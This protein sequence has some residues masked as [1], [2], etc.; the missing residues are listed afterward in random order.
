[1]ENGTMIRMEFDRSMKKIN[2]KVS[3]IG[4]K[5]VKVKKSSIGSKREDSVLII[6]D[7]TFIHYIH[8]GK[9]KTHLIACS[10]VDLGVE[11][12]LP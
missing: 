2:H 12:K 10:N 3:V 4:S 1:M 11:M 5:P 7:K 6:S 8:N 9:Y